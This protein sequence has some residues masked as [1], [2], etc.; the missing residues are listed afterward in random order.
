MGAK[1]DYELGESDSDDEARRETP[2]K[3]A[4]ANGFFTH[5]LENYRVTEKKL[6]AGAYATVVK[7][8]HKASKRDCALK[9]EISTDHEGFKKMVWNVRNLNR[10]IADSLPD[11]KFLRRTNTRSSMLLMR[12]LSA[13]FVG[14]GSTSTDASDVSR[15]LSAKNGDGDAKSPTNGKDKS[16]T[17]GKPKKR[18]ILDGGRDLEVRRKSGRNEVHRR[19][20]GLFK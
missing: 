3:R 16:P 9:K 19:N 12:R 15:R 2:M 5:S 4:K 14:R 17:N 10:P 8:T 20:I 7:C 13:P 18:G 6:G 11:D 1:E